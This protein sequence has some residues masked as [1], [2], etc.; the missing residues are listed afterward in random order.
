[1]QQFYF[2]PFTL[3]SIKQA[4]RIV[5]KLGTGILTTGIGDLDKACIQ[6][7]CRQVKLLRN[8]G[9][10]VI[11]VSSG[12]IGL[13]MG[14]LSL[15]Q[16]PK[17]LTMLQACASLGQTVLINNWQ[18][19][20]DPHALLVAQILLTREDLRAKHRYD[21]IFNTVE[22]LL[23]KGVIP[24][25][26]E[27]DAISAAEIKFGDNDTLSALVAG[28][29]NADQLFILSNV[30][31]LID[32][33]GTGEVVPYVEKITAE[34]E[35]M[36]QGTNQVTSV[37]GMISK[38][39]A[40]KIAHRFGCGV[41]IANGQDSKLFDKLLSGEPVGTYLAPH[42]MPVKSHKRWIANLDEASGTLTIDAGAATAIQES[43]KS[44]LLAGITGCEGI[45]EAGDLV[46]V[47]L[48]EGSVIAHG[49]SMVDSEDIMRMLNV[50][51]DNRTVQNTTSNVIV[52][53]DKLVLLN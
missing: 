23:A 36:A 49:L 13:G 38:L 19:G 46:K 27:N 39:S 9:I 33:Q 41:T 24:I 48:Q 43:G 52:H 5:I 29:T 51:L 53:R 20:F 3:I 47:Q 2:R 10:E 17:D 31:G 44:L 1:L 6:S 26:N 25:V 16:R 32:F 28:V 42:S 8:E 11:L 15:R 35:A 14:K 34:I 37:G 45:F 4:K 18:Q 30:S 12:A 7:L 21:A 50:A 22:R 40:A